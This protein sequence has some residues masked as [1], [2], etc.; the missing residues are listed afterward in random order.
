MLTKTSNVLDFSLNLSCPLCLIC[1]HVDMFTFH[2]YH[3][4]IVQALES[5]PPLLIP[6]AD[7]HVYHPVDLVSIFT[8]V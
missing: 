7:V 1:P 6:S 2:P 8:T 5:F 4:S 3:M